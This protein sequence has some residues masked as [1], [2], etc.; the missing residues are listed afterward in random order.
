MEF[1]PVLNRSIFSRVNGPLTGKASVPEATK[2]VEIRG[3]G[4]ERIGCEEFG[5]GKCQAM[6][7]SPEDTLCRGMVRRA[8]WEQRIS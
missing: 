6:I 3:D 5:C 8:W 1:R 7:K 2:S 4:W